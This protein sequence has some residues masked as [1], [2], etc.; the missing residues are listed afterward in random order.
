MEL[1][2]SCEAAN[3]AATQEILSIYL[4]QFCSKVYKF[5]TTK[6]YTFFFLSCSEEH[7]QHKF[8]FIRSWKVNLLEIKISVLLRGVTVFWME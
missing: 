3:C 5:A 8:T 1:S 7:F 6:Q 4:L 2:P